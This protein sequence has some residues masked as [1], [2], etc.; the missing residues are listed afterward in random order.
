[1]AARVR[2]VPMMVVLALAL[3]VATMHAQ[4][5]ARVGTPLAGGGDSRLYI[6]A[7]DGS[8]HVIDE[9]TEQ[10]VAGIKLQTGIPRSLT[11]SQ[12]RTKFYVLDS[13]LEK[14]EVVDIP[15]RTTVAT[16]T[17]SEGRSPAPFPG[18]AARNEKTSTSAFR[19]TASCC[20][21]SA[22]MSSFSRRRISPRLIPGR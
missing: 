6:G 22:T 12:S 7:Y 1:M 13:T 10:K 8:I 5:P 3:G 17:L 2:L 20:T 9:A 19:L 11:L 18:R 4:R 16:F 21:S 15:T 14:I